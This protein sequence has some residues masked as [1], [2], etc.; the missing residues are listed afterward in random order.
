MVRIQF[1]DPQSPDAVSM[2]AALGEALAVL[3][4]DSGAAS[5]DPA[6][7][8]GSKSGFAIA[9]YAETGDACGCGAIRPLEDGVAELKRM[10]ARPETR[11]VGK[12]LLE[13]LEL[14]AAS[15]GYDAVRLSTRLINTHAVAFYARNGYITIPNFGRYLGRSESVCMEKV[16]RE[17]R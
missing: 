17:T 13:F 4:G 12:A 14:K 15:F 3:T 1:E 16:L 2:I 7:V 8:R 10:Y 5:F 11:G 9:R 6:D